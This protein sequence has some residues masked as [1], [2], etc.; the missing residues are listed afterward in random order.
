LNSVAKVLSANDVSETGSH[1]AGILI[2]KSNV[3]LMEFFPKLDVTQ[4]NPRTLLEFE[5]KRTHRKI[6]LNYIYY[7]GK[8][9]RNSTGGFGTR[10]EYRLTGLTAYFKGEGAKEA[11]L[12]QFSK[13]G[14]KYFIEVVSGRTVPKTRLV[15]KGN[16]LEND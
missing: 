14:N 16:W 4:K 13:N 3:T 10:N 12:I 7:N 11:D 15:L 5:D 8:F 2:P 9:F 1:Q 6:Y